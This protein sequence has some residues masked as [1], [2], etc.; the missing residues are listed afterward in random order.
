MQQKTCIY[1][2]SSRWSKSHPEWQTA[3]GMFF[4]TETVDEAGSVIGSKFEE[5]QRRNGD[6][7]GSDS[8]PFCCFSNGSTLLLIH[9][10]GTAVSGVHP[11]ERVPQVSFLTILSIVGAEGWAIN[12]DS[13]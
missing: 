11:V 8:S 12:R 3:S 2:V 4:L 6:E 7:P 13:G 9:S 5:H 1:K 10:G